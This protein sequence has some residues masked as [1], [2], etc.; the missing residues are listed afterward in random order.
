MTRGTDIYVRLLQTV[1]Y[2]DL[3]II[4]DAGRFLH[5]I[6]ELLERVRWGC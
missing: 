1:E 2:Q 6:G 3:Y 5:E 4:I